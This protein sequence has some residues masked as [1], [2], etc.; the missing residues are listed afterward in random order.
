MVL[1]LN[2]GFDKPSKEQHRQGE[3]AQ[4]SPRNQGPILR[5]QLAIGLAIAPQCHRH[6]KGVHAARVLAPKAAPG[7]KTAVLI[8]GMSRVN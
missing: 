3:M 8:L 4:S 6:Q 7:T 2:A 5:F 1:L